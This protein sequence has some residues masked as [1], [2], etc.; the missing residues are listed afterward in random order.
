MATGARDNV[1]MNDG[2]GDAIGDAL[3]QE[4]PYPKRFPGNPS[5]IAAYK[6]L[7]A[8]REVSD[9]YPSADLTEDE[10]DEYT[11]CSYL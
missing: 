8:G 10:I 4:V 1:Y 6:S 7:A 2:D 9:D 3:T 11:N 5:N